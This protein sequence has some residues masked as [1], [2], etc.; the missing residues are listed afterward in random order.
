MFLDMVRN[1]FMGTKESN[2]LFLLLLEFEH[3]YKQLGVTITERGE[4]FYQ[5]MMQNIIDD[6]ESKGKYY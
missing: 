1:S 5:P 6:L 2:A 3:V 4:S